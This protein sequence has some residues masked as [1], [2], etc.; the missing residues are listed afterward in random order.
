MRKPDKTY[1][2]E[3]DLKH[4]INRCHRSPQITRV[5]TIFEKQLI[6]FGSK[7]TKTGGLIFVILKI[8]KKERKKEKNTLKRGKRKL[9]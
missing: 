9:S 6:K 7:L 4:K 1:R 8:N 5:H 3:H 2:I